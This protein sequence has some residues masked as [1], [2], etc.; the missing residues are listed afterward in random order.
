MSSPCLKT[1]LGQRLCEF[2]RT[3]RL[4][5][6]LAENTKRELIAV[7]DRKSTGRSD[8]E[9]SLPIHSVKIFPNVQ[10]RIYWKARYCCRIMTV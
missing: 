1:E 8:F 7:F 6:S 3:Q 10:I 5:T 4:G 2:A 9:W